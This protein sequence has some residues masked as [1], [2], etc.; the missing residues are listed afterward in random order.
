MCSGAL[1]FAQCPK[2]ADGLFT[3]GAEGVFELQVHKARRTLREV[4][5]GCDEPRAAACREVTPA[6]PAWLL[7]VHIASFT[8]FL[9]F[10]FSQN[11]L[12]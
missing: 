10:Y 6:S 4:P 2:A 7:T 5:S 9:D 8:S 1:P 12:P 11:T 3:G